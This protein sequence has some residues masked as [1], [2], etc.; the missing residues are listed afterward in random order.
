TPDGEEGKHG[1]CKFI[2]V[3]GLHRIE[4]AKR[5][6]YLSIQCVYVDF[7][8]RELTEIEENLIRNNLTVLQHA[9]ELA[10]WLEL[11][12]AESADPD[13]PRQPDEVSKGGRGNE[14]GTAKA[15]RDRGVSEARAR[16]A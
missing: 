3:S 5:L 4:A 10:R 11:T 7:A 15:A 12:G 2:L 16:R 8:Q 1:G 6:G 13:K 14:G 9:I